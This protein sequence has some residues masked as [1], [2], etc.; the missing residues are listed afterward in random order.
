MANDKYS[1]PSDESNLCLLRFSRLAGENTHSKICESVPLIFLCGSFPSLGSFL[2]CLCWSLLCCVLK[3]PSEISR[4]FLSHLSY[5]TLQTLATLF[6]SEFSASSPQ[7]KELTGLLPCCSIVWKLAQGS[8]LAVTGSLYL[9]SISQRWLF[10]IVRRPV[11][12]F[13]NHGGTY[14]VCFQLFLVEE[15]I[16]GSYHSTLTGS[17]RSPGPCYIGGKKRRLEASLHWIS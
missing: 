14:F 11:Q 8:Q 16:S 6:L 12:C 5:F 15:N 1:V 3:A 10:F 13:E 17:R 4:V 7:L 9:L 2:I